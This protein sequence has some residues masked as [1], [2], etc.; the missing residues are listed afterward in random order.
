M[1]RRKWLARREKEREW[2]RREDSGK[3]SYPVLTI[4]KA[5]GVKSFSPQVLAYRY[6]G[7]R[8]WLRLTTGIAATPRATRQKARND[9]GGRGGDA[10]SARDVSIDSLTA[11]LWSDSQ[12]TEPVPRVAHGT[13]RDDCVAAETRRMDLVTGRG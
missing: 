4:E 8:V 11:D 3:R 2:G 7:A 9:D 12:A 10:K 5:S 13:R 1:E 6:L